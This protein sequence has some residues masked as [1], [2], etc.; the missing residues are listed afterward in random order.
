MK[1]TRNE[2][3]VQQLTVFISIINPQRACAGRVT[4]V[5]LFVCLSVTRLAAIYLIFLVE[6]EE[7]FSFLWRFLRM[8]RVR[9]RENTLF[10]SYGDIC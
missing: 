1:L 10:K 8:E 6:I 2:Y 5:V 3:T 7:S 4:V 9:F